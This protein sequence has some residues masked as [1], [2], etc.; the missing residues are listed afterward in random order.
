MKIV[1]HEAA[2]ADLE[3]IFAWISHDSPKAAAAVVRRIRTR[4]NILGRPG[5]ARIGRPGLTPGTRELVEGPYI[6]VYEVDAPA[7]QITVLAVV[8]GARDRQR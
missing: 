2:V 5:L 6:V 3:A 7:Q 4:I 1:I 8:H